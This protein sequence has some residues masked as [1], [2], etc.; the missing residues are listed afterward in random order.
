MI[1]LYGLMATLLSSVIL[2]AAPQ[3][4][5]NLRD[6]QREQ[7]PSAHLHG[8]AQLTVALEGDALNIGFLAPAINTLGFEGKASSDGQIATIEKVTQSLR[9][10]DLFLFSGSDCQL[11][12][13]DIDMPPIGKQGLYQEHEHSHATHT[14]HSEV[15]ANYS[16]DCSKGKELVAISVRLISLFPSIEILEGMWLTDSQQGAID[17]TEPTGLIPIR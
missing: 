5:D 6:E 4:T 15:G 8:V 7:P 10:S 9:S 3:T 13:V 2:M 1:K 14:N 16:Y 12:Q 17:L 11:K